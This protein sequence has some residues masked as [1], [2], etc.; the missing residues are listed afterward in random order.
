M[1]WNLSKGCKYLHFAFK[2]LGLI[3]MTWIVSTL[4]SK[5]QV[6]KYFWNTDILVWQAWA[7]LFDRGCWNNANNDIKWWGVK[8]S[9]ANC[10]DWYFEPLETY[11]SISY[12][13]GLGGMRTMW[14]V[15][16]E[17]CGEVKSDYTSA[18]LS[19]CGNVFIS[20]V[21]ML[22]ISTDGRV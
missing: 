20:V 2:S 7:L 12:W 14:R 17:L 5:H 9:V 3:T 4:A 18:I 1:A 8:I 13:L 10:D 11:Q 21:W 22:K 6:L 16:S 19:N 15:S